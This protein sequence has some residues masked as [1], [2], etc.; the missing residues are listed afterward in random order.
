MS[1]TSLALVF[2]LAV[3]PL[4]TCSSALDTEKNRRVAV[5]KLS[6]PFQGVI[7]AKRCYREMKLLTHMDHE[8]VCNH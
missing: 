8:N 5:K 6:S 7:H 1:A 2:G 4:L 3:S